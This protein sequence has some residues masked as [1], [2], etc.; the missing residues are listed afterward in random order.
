[1]LLFETFFFMILAPFL[2]PRGSILEVMGRLGCPCGPFG[3]PGR[4]QTSFLCSFFRLLGP[5]GAPSGAQGSPR[6]PKRA[7][8]DAQSGPKA[9]KKRPPRATFLIFT[10]K[11]YFSLFRYPSAAEFMVLPPR[12]HPERQLWGPWASKKQKKTQ[13]RE[14]KL[15]KSP[16]EPNMTPNSAPGN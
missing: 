11:S 15:E 7:Q 5:F 12:N 13:F 9:L 3:C 16:G 1:M 2:E 14:K 4:F 6:E 10:A 8:N